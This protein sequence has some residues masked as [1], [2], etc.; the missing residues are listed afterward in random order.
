[1]PDLV[2]D[3]AL[4]HSAGLVAIG[5]GRATRSFGRLGSNVYSIIRDAPAPR[6]AS[7][8]MG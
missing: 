1:M 6:S 3:S 4:G 2:R 7:S 5:R 8:S